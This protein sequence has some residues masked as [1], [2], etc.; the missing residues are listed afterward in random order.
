MRL[1]SCFH[2]IR[3]DTVLIT[4]LILFQAGE[5]QLQVTEDDP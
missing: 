1:M 3:H 4:Q 2:P 5:P